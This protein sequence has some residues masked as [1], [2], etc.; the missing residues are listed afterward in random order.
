MNER[1]GS[2]DDARK[3]V[4]Y[5]GSADEHHYVTGALQGV[6]GV[7]VYRRW[8][9]IIA[10]IAR[11]DCGIVA[12]R[13]IYDDQIGAYLDLI[14]HRAPDTPIIVAT[15]KDLRN[16]ESALR[17][18]VDQIV[19]IEEPGRKLDTAIMHVC[20]R[21]F[22]LTVA[23]NAQMALHLPAPMRDVIAAYCRA[24]IP[25]RSLQRA[26]DVSGAGRVSI[27]RAWRSSTKELTPKTFQDWILLLHAATHRASGASWEGVA[28]TLR[29]DA[30]TLNR[31][32]RRFLGAK[33]SNVGH[34][35]L[36]AVQIEFCSRVLSALGIRAPRN[37][38]R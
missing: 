16:V 9:D 12:I 23:R 36:E 35:T 20:E 1:L 19:W 15:S 26:A 27:W 31:V 37:R 33:I 25:L 29:V 34:G 14:R 4:V 6:Q 8:Q 7:R 17:L 22:L 30:D 38:M 13:H 32:A 11:S 3:V 28:Q 24:R 5:C 18:G 10:T 21:S 2:R